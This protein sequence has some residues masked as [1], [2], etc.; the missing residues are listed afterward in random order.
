MN[1]MMVPSGHEMSTNY[2]WQSSSPM[3]VFV[4]PMGR[5][6]IDMKTVHIVQW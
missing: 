2:T 4:N 6:Q 5:R 3:K 1:D